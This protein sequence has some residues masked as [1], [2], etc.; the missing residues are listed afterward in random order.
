MESERKF[1]EIAKKLSKKST[2]VHQL[3]AVI[4]KKNKIVGMG[5]NNPYK[6]HPQSNNDFKN[7]HA[8]LDAIL[9]VENKKDLQGSVLYVYREHKNGQP[10]NSKPCKYCKMLIKKAGI[11]KV[12]YTNNGTYEEYDV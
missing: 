7:I 1:F 6:T 5:F 3:G 4:T 10:A 12:Y 11:K 9:D 8:E 2:Y